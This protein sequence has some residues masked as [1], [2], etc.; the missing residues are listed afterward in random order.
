M[1]FEATMTMRREQAVLFVDM[2]HRYGTG[3]YVCTKVQ[4][5]RYHVHVQYTRVHTCLDIQ[6]N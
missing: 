6:V 4:Q 2:Y 5:Y 1:N 3:M